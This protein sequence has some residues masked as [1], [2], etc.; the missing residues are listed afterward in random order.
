MK[1]DIVIG[2]LVNIILLGLLLSACGTVNVLMGV[3]YDVDD[4]VIGRNPI[5]E[6]GIE[7]Q[8][9]EDSPWWSWWHHN[10]SYADGWPFNNNVSGRSDR[11]GVTYKFKVR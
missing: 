5:G 8:F 2:R 9:K 3:G 10:S 1:V 11:L 6:L 4:S 7:A